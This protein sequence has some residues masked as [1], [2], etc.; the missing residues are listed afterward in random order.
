M[1]DLR[2]VHPL[3]LSLAAGLAVG[4]ASLAIPLLRDFH[5]ESAGLASLL[6]AF[7]SG[8]SVA[9]GGVARKVLFTSVSVAAGW[10][11][12]LLLLALA[13]GCFSIHGAAFWLFGPLPSIIFTIALGR[14]VRSWPVWRP[15]FWTGFL[16]LLI[17]V[18]P[19]LAQFFSFPQ[20]YFY[21][22]IWS[23]WPGPIYEEVV[24]FPFEM[25]GFRMHTLLWAVLLA[26]LPQFRQER[27]Y[28]AIAILSLAAILFN[29]SQASRWGWISPEERLQAH[30]GAVH[31]TSHFRLYHSAEAMDRQEVEQ[32]AGEQEGW[33]LDIV[34]RLDLDLEIYRE[35]PIH[36][37]IYPDEEF[38]RRLTGAGRT[39]YVPVWLRQDQ[40]HITRSRAQ[41]SLKHELVHIVAKQFGNRF[42]ASRNIGLVEGLAVALSLDEESTIYPDRMIAGRQDLPDAEELRQILTLIGFYRRPGVV[43]YT[44]SGSFVGHLLD[45]RPVSSFKEAYRTGRIEAAYSPVPFKELVREWHV[46]LEAIPLDEQD[47]ARSRALFSAPSIFD[48]PCPRIQDRSEIARLLAPPDVFFAL[49]V[50]HTLGGVDLY[51]AHLSGLCGDLQL[52]GR[53]DPA[54]GG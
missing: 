6:L 51:P 26:A 21:N 39:S 42:G 19:T 18:I 49:D 10:A 24:L 23:Y 11:L 41:A 46:R 37:Y 13:T 1:R 30:L 43:S 44:V 35:R 8:V 32:M 2:N 15:E 48:K 31:E 40:T 22:H 47:L 54:P 16:T 7:R 33:L 17:A 38:K 52:I 4:I 28:R 25:A 20:L 29:H 50:G 45:T 36:T 5:W 53:E 14:L 9:R 27:L 12:P 34:E 3:A